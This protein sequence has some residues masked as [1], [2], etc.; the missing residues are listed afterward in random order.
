MQNNPGDVWICEAR[1]YLESR[2]GGGW[3]WTEPAQWLGLSLMSHTCSKP[4]KVSCYSKS[5]EWHSGPNWGPRQPFQFP[6]IELNFG[7]ARLLIISRNHCTFLPM[8][9][10]SFPSFHMECTLPACNK[11]LFFLEN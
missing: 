3:G 10:C 6:Y 4:S 9:F 8:E 11:I 1:F 7:Q 2:K 5:S